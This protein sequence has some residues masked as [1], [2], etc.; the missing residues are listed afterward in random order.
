MTVNFPDAPSTNDTYTFSG[1]K[2]LWNGSGWQLVADAIKETL[3][4]AKGDLVAGSAADTAVRVA[5][6]SN[7]TLLVADSAQSSGVKWASLTAAQVPTLESAKVPTVT[8]NTQ[9]ASYTLVLGDAGK[10]VEISNAAGVTLTV[11]TNASVA[12][13]TGT[14]IDLLQ[15]GAGQVT[16]AGAGGVTVN[17]DQGNLKL[18][19]QWSGATLVKRDTNTWVLIGNL[20]A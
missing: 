6:G 14:K 19:G 20:T 7:D 9:T 10:L 17:S 16:V 11:P 4:D 5:V 3:I 1:R 2:W 13:P 12:F 18:T 15:T 8:R